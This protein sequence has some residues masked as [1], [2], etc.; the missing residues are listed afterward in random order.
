MSP[1]WQLRTGAILAAIAVAAGA[2]GAHALRESLTPDRLDTWKVAASYQL[3][4]AV[5]LVALG[6]SGRLT[7]GAGIW[8]A[9]LLVLGCLVFSGSLYALCLS[10]IGK[11]GAITPIGGLSFISGWVLIAVSWTGSADN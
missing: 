8:G 6:A 5:A 11:L 4:H 1:V 3:V 10:G 9:N 2:F 7:S